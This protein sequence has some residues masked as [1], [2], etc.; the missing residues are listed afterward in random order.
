MKVRESVVLLAV[1]FGCAF[2]AIGARSQSTAPGDSQFTPLI[3]SVEGPE[4][5]RAYCAS[6][7]GL[8]AKGSGPV[9]PALKAKVPD[10]TLLMQKHGGKFPSAL[11]R[12]TIVGDDQVLSHGTRMMPV[13]GPVFHQVEEDVDRGHVR[14]ENLVNYLQSLQAPASK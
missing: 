11:V 9:A 1:V 7:H 12:K 14:V 3:H 5:F 6:C 10:L 4:L 2:A 8:D 13:W